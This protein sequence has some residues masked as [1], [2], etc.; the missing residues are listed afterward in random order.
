MFLFEFVGW[1]NLFLLIGIIGVVIGCFMY[2]IV[3]DIL[4]EYGF[5]VDIEFYE[6]LEKVNIV[7]GIKF[8]IKN[9]LIWYNL[10]IM[11]FFVGF[12]SVFISLWGVRYIMDVYGVSKSFFVFI[13]LF[14]IY[15]F[16]F[17]LIIMDFVFVKIRF[18]KFNIIKFGVMIDLFI[19]IVIVVVY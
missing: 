7:D 12:I 16:I 3:R 5:N 14:F 8:V 17:G 13:V 11:F 1:R 6:K 19:W 9:K 10:M 2:I 15:G 4:K 18:S